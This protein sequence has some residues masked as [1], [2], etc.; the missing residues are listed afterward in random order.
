MGE[1]EKETSTGVWPVWLN[2]LPLAHPIGDQACNLGMCP[3][4][5]LNWQPP[6]AQDDAQPAEPH[7]LGRELFT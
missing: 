2:W 4:W 1:G 6:G 3:G 7:W 5:E